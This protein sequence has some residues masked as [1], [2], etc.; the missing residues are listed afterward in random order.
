L[1][2]V[3][4]VQLLEPL[5]VQMGTIQFLVV[6][7]PQAAV[8]VVVIPLGH[9]RLALVALAAVVLVIQAAQVLVGQEILHQQLRLR[10]ITAAQE[11]AALLLVVAVVV[12]LLPLEEFK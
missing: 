6:L 8:E 1:A 4:W 11:Q 7:L 5:P 10:E 2:L 12:A 9:P 3:E